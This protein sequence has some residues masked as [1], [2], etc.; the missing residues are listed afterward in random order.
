M[1]TDYPYIETNHYH[2]V[3]FT[4]ESGADEIT[5][6]S[7]MDWGLYLEEPVTVS[8][9]KPNTYMVEV[10]GRNGSL[11]LTESAIGRVTY[12]DRE[13]VFPF[14][15]RK[16]RNEWN[17]SYQALLNA[18][19]GRACKITCSDDPDYYYEGRVTVEEWGASGK[20]AFPEVRAK[21]RPYKTKKGKSVYSGKL[22]EAGE[23]EQ[24]MV[25]LRCPFNSDNLYSYKLFTTGGYFDF[26][27]YSECT[28][29]EFSV[30]IKESETRLLTITDGTNTYQT[31][32]TYSNGK[33][34]KWRIER[35]AV[36]AAGVVWGNIEKI[37]MYGSRAYCPMYGVIPGAMSITTGAS[38]KPAVPEIYSTA[39]V[40][41]TAEG[42]SYS[43]PA[44]Q[45]WL[46]EKVTIGEDGETLIFRPTGTVT[47]S[48]S[49]TVTYQE[50]WL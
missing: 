22:S 41:M 29:L 48:D 35:T 21:V 39:A 45:K 8:T 16:K 42:T 9:P 12:Q 47:E 33:L 11:D 15:C 3:E 24:A 36:E 26:A 49:V 46:S 20:M 19:H 6:N 38:G 27:K 4:R 7:Y 30:L 1:A 23:T 14:V 31:Q 40:T 25:G 32:K 43:I 18:V 10:P 50:G 34:E 37:K 2:Y 13:M 17:A 5:Y 44:N 28:A